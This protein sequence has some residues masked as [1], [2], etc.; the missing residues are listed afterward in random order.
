MPL[1]KKEQI[2][3]MKLMGHEIASHSALHRN[4]TRLNKEELFFE[5]RDSKI[6][7]ENI[8]GQEVVGFAY[9]YGLYTHSVKSIVEH[10]YNY[11]RSL[12]LRS[13]KT[14]SSSYNKQSFKYALCSF[15]P[16]A[17]VAYLFHSIIHKGRFP[18]GNIIVFHKEP[19]SEI[20][21][22]LRT[23]KLVGAKFCSIKDLVRYLC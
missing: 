15:T 5:I 22:L 13:V 17:F 10:Y 23:L 14:C 6:S 8:L 2:Q 20:Y 3:A 4:L 18:Y 9:P 7:L 19:L 16:K 12:Y 21:T 11:A 1:L